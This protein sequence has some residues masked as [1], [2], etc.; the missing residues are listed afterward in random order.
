MPA[1]SWANPAVANHPSS[2]KLLA[3]M[4][5]GP[6]PLSVVSFAPRQVDSALLLA[7]AALLI[8]NSHL[9]AFYPK[10]WLAADG[11][12]GN[13]LFIMLSGYG[14]QASLM[15]KR[16][17]FFS[18]ASRR[19]TRLYPT[20]L[21]AAVVVGL[22]Q[23]IQA[24][25]AGPGAVIEFLIYPTPYTYVQII[26]PIYVAL[27]WAGRWRSV[28]VLAAA[29][30]VCGLTYAWV[31][32]RDS[33]SLPAGTKLSLGRQTP[34]GSG[35]I[36]WTLAFI[37]AAAAC[38]GLRPKFTIG[39]VTAVFML[40]SGYF[41]LKFL[42]VVKGNLTTVYPVL[43][44]AVLAICALAML[45]FGDPKAV[46]ALPAPLRRAVRWLAV[47]TLETYVVHELLLTWPAF[48]RLPFPVNIAALLAVTL[49]VAYA[50]HIAAAR[51]RATLDSPARRSTASIDFYGR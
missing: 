12:L 43:L 4:A 41:T 3:H 28:R 44:F 18:Y 7:V 39:R 22:P 42:M 50:V 40:L 27:Y 30:V 35:S 5:A 6:D 51:V 49:A 1:F 16:Q 13:S 21:I 45:T 17:G 15:A 37:G 2:V 32:F 29:V 11:T 33:L 47:L 23:M 48:A 34:F 20:V 9:E 38:A 10:P 24:A 46:D 31:G 26:L 25:R 14:V 19:L 8:I 36:N